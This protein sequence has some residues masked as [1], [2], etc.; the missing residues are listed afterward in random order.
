[1]TSIS[2]E[3]TTST[4]AQDA[5][6]EP[7]RGVV[8]SLLDELQRGSGD[9]DKRR[10]VEEWMRNLAE[11]YPGFSILPGLRDYYVAEADRLRSDFEGAADL[12]EKLNLGR[13]IE[14]FLERA[15]DM[16]RRIEEKG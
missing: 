16:D 2:D 12:T 10:Q 8:A 14:S 9:K 1:M 7:L 13:M 3:K 4:T 15:A 5:R 6:N 11:K